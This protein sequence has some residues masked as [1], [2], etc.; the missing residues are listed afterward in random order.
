LAGEIDVVISHHII[1]EVS[2]NFQK[3]WF[4][5]K[6]LGTDAIQIWEEV[7][8]IA[9][10]VELDPDS[11][12]PGL[13]SRPEDDFVLATA[14][15]ARVDYLVTGDKQLRKLATIDDTTI[16]SPAEMLVVL[17]GTR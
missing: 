2:R 16:V 8:S 11:A 12:L 13:A 3:P 10:V 7:R 6:L 9:E 5:E 15:Q 14:L 17:E 1:E 4:A